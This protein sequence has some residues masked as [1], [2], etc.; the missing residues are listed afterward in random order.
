MPDETTRETAFV[1]F[2]RVLDDV[3]DWSK[4]QYNKGQVLMHT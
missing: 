2:R 1:E 3:L 4:A